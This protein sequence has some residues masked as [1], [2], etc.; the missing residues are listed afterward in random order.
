[1]FKG[2]S[3]DAIIRELFTYKRLGIRPAIGPVKKLLRVLGDPHKKTRFFHVAGTNG[4]GSTTAMIAS[5]MEEAG[6][7]TGAFYSPHVYDYRERFLINGKKVS[8][9]EI[10]ETLRWMGA[11]WAAAK[12]K[13]RRL[14]EIITFFEW[15]TA[16][17]FCLFAKRK[18]DAAVMETGMGGNFDA[19]NVVTPEVTVITNISLEH[20]PIL[21]KT[22]AAIAG[23]KAG[24]LKRRKPLVCGEGRGTAREVLRRSAKLKGSPGFFLGEDFRITP[25]GIFSNEDVRALTLMPLMPGAYQVKNAAVATQAVLCAKR[26]SVTLRHIRRGIERAE[27]PGRFETVK[28]KRKLIFDVAHNPAAFREL[29]KLIS[30]TMPDGKINVAI[31]ILRGKDYRKMLKTIAPVTRRMYCVT[32]PDER[33]IPAETIH[34]AGVSLG[35]RSSVVRDVK[36]ALAGPSPVLVTGSFTTVDYVKANLPGDHGNLQKDRVLK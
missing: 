12:K 7:K 4:K 8:K 26:F 15:T 30:E 20:T 1:M 11:K 36:N 9:K 32:P 23:E 21:G 25:K 3:Y 14:P 22:K 29:A 27:L 5:I 33:A 28:G 16:L 6:Y 19:T 31:G 18:V 2:K 35:I 17:A 24:I 10:A 34:E 13:K